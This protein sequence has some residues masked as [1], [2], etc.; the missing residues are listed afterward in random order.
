MLKDSWTR[1][2]RPSGRHHALIKN[3]LVTDPHRHRRTEWINEGCRCRKRK[4]K[5]HAQQILQLQFACSPSCRTH[6]S[7]S[8][9]GLLS[10]PPCPVRLLASCLHPVS[11]PLLLL[12]STS[13]LPVLWKFTA[14]YKRHSHQTHTH[15]H[16]EGVLSVVSTGLY[17]DQDFTLSSLSQL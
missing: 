5:M 12:H 16:T 3:E 14:S 17:P 10:I 7:R 4:Q 1:L 2:S 11:S 9:G 13:S 15:T 8:W 6:L